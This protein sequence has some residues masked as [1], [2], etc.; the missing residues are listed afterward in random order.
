LVAIIE[1]VKERDCPDTN[2][3]ASRFNGGGDGGDDGKDWDM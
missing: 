1:N 2:G 3:G